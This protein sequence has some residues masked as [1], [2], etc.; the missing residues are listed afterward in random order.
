M[1]IAAMIF[2]FLYGSV[3]LIEVA[4]PPAWLPIEALAE[5][6][7]GIKFELY[8][9]ILPNPASTNGTLPFMEIIVKLA[10]FELLFGLALSMY[11]HVKKKNYIALLGEHGIGMVLY[12]LAIYFAIGPGFTPNIGPLTINLMLAGLVCSFAEPIIHGILSHHFSPMESISEGIG[13]LMMTFVEGLGNMFSFLRVAAF[14]VAHASLAVA[15]TALGTTMGPVVGLVIMNVIAMTF[16]LISSSVQ[17][18]RL[19]YYEFMGKFFDGQG[20]PFRPFKI[21]TVRRIKD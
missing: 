20:V 1:G 14:A 4:H 6:G 10:V 2:G 5:T 16:E 21:P 7:H 8:T 11:N 19:L 12:V 18:M 9:A 15:A 3:F 13:A 17:S